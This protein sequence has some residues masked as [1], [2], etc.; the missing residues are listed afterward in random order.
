MTISILGAG[1][2]GLSCSSFIGHERCQIFEKNSYAGGHIAT[3]TQNGCYW[4]EGPHV[5]FTKHQKVRDLLTE[6]TI[7]GLLEYPAIVG[8]WYQGSWIP[9][10]AQSNLY[11]VPRP[12]ADRCLEDF[13]NS[14]PPQAAPSEAPPVH[15]GE[16][17]EQAFGKTFAETFSAAYTR[18][19]WTCNPN[20]MSVDW[21]GERV[22]KPDV[23]TVRSGYHQPP[24]DNTHYI[25]TVRYP[26]SGGFSSI[27]D[28]ISKG[29]RVNFDHDVSSIDF[30]A[31]VIEFA[32]GKFYDFEFLINTIPLVEFVSKIKGVPVEILQACEQLSC[33]S[34][35]LVNIVSETPSPHPYHWL[36]VYD[37]TMYSTRI[38][39]THLLSQASTPPGQAGIQVE[40]YSSRYRPFTESHEK[41]SQRVLEEVQIMGLAEKPIAMSTQFIPYANIICD[42]PRRQAL[43]H[44]LGWLEGV[45]L[46]RE[47]DDLQPMTDWTKASKAPTR[48]KLALAGR[49]AQ[50][51]YF[52]T[53]DCILRAEQLASAYR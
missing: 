37:E 45:G 21:V 27:A 26:V 13:L 22:F 51:K 20:Q 52:W 34:L 15:Y 12:L 1:L 19:Y 7:G 25:T 36:Y 23:E 17:L 10:P 18:K 48:P 44:V 50:W 35:L 41:I 16:W 40:V 11:A 31:G 30:D 39:Q 33:S 8:N 3:H 6:S 29:S 43:N 2:S 46:I 49:F 38:S 9:H 5:S 28:G 14:R 53:D 24:K 47:H 32:N 42:L 4:D